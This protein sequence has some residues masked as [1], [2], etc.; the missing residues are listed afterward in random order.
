MNE[1]KFRAWDDKTKTMSAPF[2]LFSPDIHIYRG[3]KLMQYTGLKDKNGM[4]VYEGDIIQTKDWH[5]DENGRCVLSE[6][7]SYMKKTIV[8]YTTKHPFIGFTFH[9]KCEII[10]NIYENPE[11]IK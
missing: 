4:E 6:A 5:T 11:L 3:W 2:T 10:G 9:D 7:N 1:L 8:E